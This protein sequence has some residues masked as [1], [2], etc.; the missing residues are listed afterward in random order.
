MCQVG[1]IRARLLSWYDKN[2][3]MLP[4][5]GDPPPWTRRVGSPRTDALT[6]LYCHGD[7]VVFKNRTNKTLMTNISCSKHSCA[8]ESV[9][10]SWSGS[11]FSLLRQSTGRRGEEKDLNKSSPQRQSSL[12]DV[13][14][15]A[16]NHV[17]IVCSSLLA[18][19]EA[20]HLAAA[21]QGSMLRLEHYDGDSRS[22]RRRVHSYAKAPSNTME[23]AKAF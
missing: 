8:W 16:H 5:R 17:Q 12:D 18:P 22:R 4:W 14:V 19:C 2:R 15:L 9:R 3:R 10:S 7:H 1:T 11:L 23:V 13:G 20:G 6:P 21:V